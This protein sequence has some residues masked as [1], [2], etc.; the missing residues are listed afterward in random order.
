MAH[1]YRTQSDT[2]GKTKM[3]N[4]V[5]AG[6]KG[7]WQNGNTAAAKGM[8]A[9]N[10]PAGGEARVSGKKSETRLDKLA[11]GGKSKSKK[12]PKVNIKIVAPNSGEP[13]ISPVAA[14]IGPAGLSGLP[15]APPPGI[16]PM[17]MRKRGGVAKRAEG[18]EVEEI[19]PTQRAWERG[20]YDKT[21]THMSREAIKN[22]KK[23]GDSGTK[24]AYKDGGKVTG[25]SYPK[26]IKPHVEVPTTGGTLDTEAQMKF[27]KRKRGGS[28]MKKYPI[29]GGAEGGLG[30]IQLSHAQKRDRLAR[31]S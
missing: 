26:S 27:L 30:R 28:A 5:G 15:P 10:T 24:S 16:P 21:G 25:S 20:E 18:G 7:G 8:L 13:P 22:S 31:G 3:H 1:P 14:P 17:G 12:S 9:N 4:M 29:T 19:S 23:G 6:A 2:A 11:R